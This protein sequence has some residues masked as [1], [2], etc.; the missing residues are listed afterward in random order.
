MCIF[1]RV[2]KGDKQRELH[3]PTQ[4]DSTLEINKGKWG[5]GSGMYWTS[6]TLSS[7][8]V[9]RTTLTLLYDTGRRPAKELWI[10]GFMDFLPLSDLLCFISLSVTETE[11]S[12]LHILYILPLFCRQAP[13]TAPH[14]IT[15]QDNEEY[16]QT[17]KNSM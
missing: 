6:L 8:C 16:R 13:S 9:R 15:A 10:Y 7:V 11:L 17:L 14:G 5:P 3:R 12:E 2:H 4:R 1:I